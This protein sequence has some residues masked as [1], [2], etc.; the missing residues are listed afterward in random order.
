MKEDP[1]SLW[2]GEYAERFQ[3]ANYG[4]SLAGYVLRESHKLLER[5]FGPNL[6]FARVLEIGAGSG[7]HLSYVRH[8]FD[9]YCMTDSSTRMLE[10]ARS[11]HRFP[12]NI[13][14]READ[15]TRL[16]FDDAGFDR[17]IA[18]HVLEHLY[19]P[20]EVLR[21]WARVLKPGGILSLVL[22]CDPGLLWRLGR[23]FGPRRRGRANGLDYDYVMAREH[24]NA[25]TNL[26]ALI[27]YYFDDKDENWW[28]ALVPSTDLNLIYTVNIRR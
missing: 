17:L 23:Y 4:K 2:T 21:E 20:H 8:G 13:I 11:A 10:A 19:R 6:R 16:D 27:R 18:V 5:P 24:V 26:V 14:V 7:I 9:E 15:A 22:P 3:Q 28:P 12:E 1:P 25:I